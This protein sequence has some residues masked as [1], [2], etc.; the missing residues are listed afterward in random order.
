MPDA[1]DVSADSTNNSI[2]KAKM[3]VVRET[4][5]RGGG[6]YNPMLESGIFPI[7]ARQM[8]RVGEKTGS[9]GQQLSKAA[10]YYEREVSFHIK[11]ATDLF[12]PAVILVVGLVVGFIAV[13]QVAAMYSIFGQIH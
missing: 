5:V 7:A 12:E 2:F 6:F 4:V 9:L 13:A 10:T 1:I 8:I 3:T 11:R